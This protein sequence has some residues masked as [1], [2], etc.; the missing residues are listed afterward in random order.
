[1]D[2]EDSHLPPKIVTMTM[3][4]VVTVPCNIMAPGGTIVATTP[5]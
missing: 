1:M 4:V 3:T 5:T 2:T